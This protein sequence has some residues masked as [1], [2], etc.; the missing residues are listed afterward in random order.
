MATAQVNQPGLAIGARS[1]LRA[2]LRRI[3]RRRARLC[4]ATQLCRALWVAVVLLAVVFALDYLLNLRVGARLSLLLA[5]GVAWAAALW[6]HRARDSR[7]G[8]AELRTA[9]WLEQQHALENDLVAALQFEK[10]AAQSWGSRILR[11]AVIGYVGQ[12]SE[13][14]DADWSHERRALNRQALYAGAAL[15]AVGLATLIAPAHLGAFARRLALQPARYPTATRI[16]TV[17]VNG[18]PIDIEHGGTT[19]RLPYGQPVRVAANA[20]GAIPTAGIALLRT[21]TDRAAAE[22]TLEADATVDGHFNL[23]LSRLVDDVELS[24]RLGDDTTEPVNIQAIALPVVTVSLDATPPEYARSQAAAPVGSHQLAVVEGTDVTIH[25]ECANKGLRSAECTIGEARFSLRSMADNRHWTLL[26]MGT[27]LANIHE[28]MR[29]EIQVVDEDGLSLAEPLQGTIRIKADRP[30]RVTA[31]VVTQHV[32]PT[33]KPRISFGST[34]DFGLASLRVRCLIQRAD[35]T[36][37]ESTFEVPLAEPLPRL[38]QGRWPF[39]LR[40][41]KLMKGDQ[42]KVTLEATDWRGKTPGK[43]ASSEPLVLHVTDE[44]GVLAAMSEA[45]QRTAR[46]MDAIIQRQLG[47]G[48]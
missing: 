14:L 40:D 39:E 48:E 20:E 35:G 9:L 30:P 45:D 21:G 5:A 37:D 22:A 42:L 26:P 16:V 19:L 17:S 1:P 27:P 31:A 8:D 18:Q 33:G 29:Y 11:E 24:L 47:L 6:L 4:L 13:E 23:Q 44:R 32:L 3:A 41:L 46:Q 43:T 38:A 2:R 15:L 36:S 25:V 7:A 10:P 34:D 12:F 28:L